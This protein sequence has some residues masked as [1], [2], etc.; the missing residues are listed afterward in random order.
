MNNSIFD[1]FR[2]DHLGKRIFSKIIFTFGLL[3]GISVYF[4]PLGDPDFSALLIWAENAMED[5]DYL[6]NATIS[7]IPITMG[8]IIYIL[9]VTAV[10]FILI[11]CS[12]VYAG[13]YIRQYRLDHADNSPG[14]SGYLVPPRFLIPSGIGKLVLRMVI[15]FC[16]S[17]VI[18]IPAAFTLLYL[19]LVFIIILPCISMFPA[20]Y[21]SGDTGFFGS[22]VEMVRVTKGYYL[23]NARNMTLIVCLLFAGRW[24]TSFLM[25]FVPSAAYIIGPLIDIFLALSFGR[26]VGKVYCRMREIPGGFR[27][28][29]TKLHGV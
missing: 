17:L 4:Y 20:C 12:I 6:M 24:I 2:I 13:V 9:H 8:N 16:F 18:F 22:F 26:Y 10:D 11:M 19:F 27:Y 29:V 14:D 21:L 1:I 5:V 15:V 25:S 3:V 28:D 23:V 7:D